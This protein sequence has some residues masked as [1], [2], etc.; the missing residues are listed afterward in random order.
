MQSLPPV[1]G[2]AAFSGTG[3]TTLLIQLIPLLRAR[4]LRSGLIKHGHHT[5]EV[6]KPGKDSYLLRQAGATQLMVASA[7]RTLLIKTT[8]GEADLFTLLNQVAG[9]N[10]DIILVEGFKH[11]PIPKIELHRSRL[12]Y[13]LLCRQ[14]PAIIAVV[15][16]A[17]LSKPVP[18]PVLALNDPPAIAAFIQSHFLAGKR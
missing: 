3:K 11:H 12:G 9:Q 5:F 6:D 18:I 17:P 1:L 10:L 16:D 2:F 15:T 8:T 7:R 14:D 4:G 13:P